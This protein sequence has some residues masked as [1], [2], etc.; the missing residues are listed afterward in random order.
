MHLS[1]VRSF[2]PPFFLLAFGFLTFLLFIRFCLW[3]SM[4]IFKFRSSCRIK[5]STWKWNVIMKPLNI[6]QEWICAVLVTIKCIR[7]KEL[8]NQ[9]PYFA[10]KQQ[11]WN[12][13][14]CDRAFLRRVD[15]P[16]LRTWARISSSSCA[17]LSFLIISSSCLWKALTLS[18]RFRQFSYRITVQLVNFK[19]I[20][21]Y[22]EK[23]VKQ[24]T[25][26]FQLLVDTF[27]VLR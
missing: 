20:H 25:W 14:S 16:N 17:R 6:F 11:I 12:Y 8:E 19:A 3:P 13:G 15:Q 22:G 24:C 5:S 21:I 23:C 26:N 7:S 1:F 9:V 2:S 27:F 10:R 4:A 18:L